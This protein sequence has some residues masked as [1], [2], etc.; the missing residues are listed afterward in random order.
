MPTLVQTLCHS[1]KAFINQWFGCIFDLPGEKTAK[2]RTQTPV[3]VAKE[4]Q[5]P[6]MKSENCFESTV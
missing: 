4:R 5:H 6:V 2:N 1:V 3:F